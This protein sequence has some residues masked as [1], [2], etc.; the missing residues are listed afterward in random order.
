M[1][2]VWKIGDVD[3]KNQAE[4]NCDYIITTYQEENKYE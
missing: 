3:N 2:I 4:D 1:E